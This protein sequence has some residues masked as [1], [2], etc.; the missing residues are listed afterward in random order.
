[1]VYGLSRVI[2][3]DVCMLQKII[4]HDQENHFFSSLS[5]EFINSFWSAI[6]IKICIGEQRRINELIND[7]NKQ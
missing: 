2:T 5:V 7:S 3:N 1:M 6:Y 4:F